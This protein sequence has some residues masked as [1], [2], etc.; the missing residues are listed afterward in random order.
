MKAERYISLVAALQKQSQ[1]IVHCF[2]PSYM[3]VYL[4]IIDSLSIMIIHLQ[5]PPPPQTYTHTRSP[6]HISPSLSPIQK[7]NAEFNMCLCSNGI[8]IFIYTYIYSALLNW[9][10][11][12]IGYCI[13]SFQIPNLLSKIFIFLENHVPSGPISCSL[14]DEI[15]IP[16]IK[17]WTWSEVPVLGTLFFGEGW[18]L[19]VNASLTWSWIS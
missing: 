6:L 3:Y 10:E 1:G 19:S 8:Y 17:S 5:S 15:N 2:S 11:E 7:K 9:I 18:G 16:V 13:I 4:F 12:S 14:Y